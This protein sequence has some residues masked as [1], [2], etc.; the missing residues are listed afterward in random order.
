MSDVVL[1]EGSGLSSK[2]RPPM[3]TELQKLVNRYTKWGFSLIPIVKGT[4]KP[5]VEWKPY[6]TR[7]P[8]TDE[9]KQW[10][11]A[12][13]TG[14]AIVCGGISQ[15]LVVLDFDQPDLFAGFSAFW[16]ESYGDAIDAMTPVV[17]TG[18]GGRHVYLKMKDLPPLYHPLGDERKLLPDIQSEGGYVLAPPTMHPSGKRYE[19]TGGASVIFEVA[20]LAELMFDIPTKGAEPK[21]GNDP[22]WVVG[23]LNG[24][25]QPGRDVACMKLAG[26]YKSKGLAKEETL[27]LL[28]AWFERCTGDSSFTEADVEKCVE[29]SYGYIVPDMVADYVFKHNAGVF[30]FDFAS[31]GVSVRL[32]RL[33]EKSDVTTAEIVITCTLPA[34][35]MGAS[36]TLA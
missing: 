35:A 14:V 23:L 32:D 18:G 31:E 36:D 24:V 26:H 19:F 30:Q 10:F 27:A 12:N 9:L 33:H 7:R 34:V 4:K 1:R 22:N 28:M 20:D 2:R 11:S 16:K 6:Q 13:N 29:S 17:E 3:P 15:N 21:T 5:S 8:K 25:A